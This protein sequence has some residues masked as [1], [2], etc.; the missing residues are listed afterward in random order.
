MAQWLALVCAGIWA[1]LCLYLILAER[2]RKSIDIANPGFIFYRRVATNGAPLLILLIF[3]GCGA[4]IY[5]WL[6]TRSIEFVVGALILLVMFPLSAMF[7]MP[8]DRVMMETNTG[9]V[10]A[11][12]EQLFMRWWWVHLLRTALAVAACGFFLSGLLS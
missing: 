8:L 2:P 12:I 5:A 3:L 11:A 9:N 6:G 4:G 7:V 1:L 10:G